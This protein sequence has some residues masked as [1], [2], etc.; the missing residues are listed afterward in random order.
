ML[1]EVAKF[2]TPFGIGYG[3]SF[4]FNS[5]YLYIKKWISGGKGTSTHRMVAISLPINDEMHVIESFLSLST[6]KYFI[7]DSSGTN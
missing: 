3:S 1:I 2:Y 7:F 4:F 5:S 6:A